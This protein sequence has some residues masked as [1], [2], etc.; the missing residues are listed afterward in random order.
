MECYA[1]KPIKYREEENEEDTEIPL[2]VQEI[3]GEYFPFRNDDSRH[4]SFEEQEY[5]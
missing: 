4:D 3:D 1:S 2:E 5:D